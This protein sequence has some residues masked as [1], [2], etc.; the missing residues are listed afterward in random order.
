MLTS[1][2]LEG[3]ILSRLSALAV[4]FVPDAFAFAGVAI[5][6]GV[7]HSHSALAAP[8]KMSYGGIIWSHLFLSPRSSCVG[9]CS[10]G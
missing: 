3:A 5:I 2:K 7:L 10:V 4:V 8:Y 9:A 6:S 1:A